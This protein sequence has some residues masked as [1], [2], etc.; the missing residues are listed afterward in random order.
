M[1]AISFVI[2]G[3]SNSIGTI[4][5][6]AAIAAIGF[7]S[8]QPALFSMCIRSEIPLKRSVGSN[9]LYIGMDLGLFLGPI[10]GS[11]IYEMY[12]YSVMF[13]TG[14]LIV[15]FAFISFIIILPLYHRRV[16]MLESIESASA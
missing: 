10:I 12:N 9:T 5:A 15:L 3:F 13:K 2:V 14:A 1:Y 11:I 7:G 6:G 4:L 16:N 8:S